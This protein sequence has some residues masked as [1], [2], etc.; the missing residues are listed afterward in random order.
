MAKWD[1]YPAIVTKR[2]NGDSNRY[3]HVLQIAYFQFFALQFVCLSF[4]ISFFIIDFGKGYVFLIGLYIQTIFKCNVTTEI[5]VSLLIIFQIT[6][7]FA[8]C[9]RNRQALCNHILIQRYLISFF[10]INY[11]LFYCYWFY[12]NNQPMKHKYYNAVFGQ[13]HAHI[14]VPLLYKTRLLNRAYRHID[15]FA[16]A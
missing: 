5:V 2:R 15:I 13:T 14:E 12:N 6:K 10:I 8:K 9:Q 1:T 11:R 3:N 7:Q 4:N 16:P